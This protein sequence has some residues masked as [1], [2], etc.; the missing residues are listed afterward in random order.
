MGS[1]I[2]HYWPPQL[3]DESAYFVSWVDSEPCTAQCTVHTDVNFKANLK[4]RSMEET[5]TEAL[6]PCSLS[7][8]PIAQSQRC[9]QWKT[10]E[11]WLEIIC[12]EEAFN[13]VHCL[14]Q[15]FR[16]FCSVQTKFNKM[17]IRQKVDNYN[18]SALGLA[19]FE[20]FCVMK[21]RG[22]L[23]VMWGKRKR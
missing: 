8:V 22:V 18:I 17:Q 1:I 23:P 15:N 4:W 12:V 14:V 9:L 16:M 5:H 2:T 10:S 11:Y 7:S 13:I 3:A 20:T 21:T 6:R 19:R